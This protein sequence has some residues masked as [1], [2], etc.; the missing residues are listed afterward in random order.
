[1]GKTNS[2]RIIRLAILALLLWFNV[3]PIFESVFRRLL[4][5]TLA[6][7]RP[8]NKT[9]N[10]IEVSHLFRR[11]DRVMNK[12]SMTPEELLELIKQ[13]KEKGYITGNVPTNDPEMDQLTKILYEKQLNVSTGNAQNDLSQ[14]GSETGRQYFILMLNPR[15]AWNDSTDRNLNI[16]LEGAEW[17]ALFYEV[18][19]CK[20]GD[21]YLPGDNINEWTENHKLKFQQSIPNYPMLGRIWDTYIDVKYDPEEIGKL[22]AECLMIKASTSNV[23]ALE[24]LSKL[25]YA[26]DQALKLKLGLY[27]SCD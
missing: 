13:G 26:C 2:S 18:L 11:D 25:I 14:E 17:T 1:M 23:R 16:Y 4:P 24:G 22:R 19:D 20:H 12:K 6:V 8:A 15:E 21:P 10:E 3:I 9:N 27:L 7:D 5:H